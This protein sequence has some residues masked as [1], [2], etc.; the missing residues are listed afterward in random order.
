MLLHTLF[1]ILGQLESYIVSLFTTCSS[2]KLTEFTSH[3]TTLHQAAASSE[4]QVPWLHQGI[5]NREQGSD[6]SSRV[7]NV[8]LLFTADSTAC[9]YTRERRRVSSTLQFH[10]VL[11]DGGQV[12]TTRWGN[13]G[14][15]APVAMAPGGGGAGGGTITNFLFHLLVRDWDLKDR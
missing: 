3:P 5:E 6:A 11:N 15:L 13:S 4:K 8:L 14:P 10:P 12:T 1:D 2:P 9:I 7:H